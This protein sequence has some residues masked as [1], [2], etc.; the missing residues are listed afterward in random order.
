M[1]P[2]IANGFDYKALQWVDPDP[3]AV[4]IGFAPAVAEADENAGV[5]AA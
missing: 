3:I 5:V 2:T 1:K 4:S